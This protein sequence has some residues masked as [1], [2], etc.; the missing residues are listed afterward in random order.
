MGK[1]K[2]VTGAFRTCVRCKKE[3]PK[4]YFKISEWLKGDG[5]SVCFL[6]GDSD[7]KRSV[8]LVKCLGY[9]GGEFLS[10]HGERVCPL[11]KIKQAKFGEFRNG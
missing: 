7:K 5:L 8:K 9:C 6:C 2:V 10:Y 1:T 4:R 3:R 11:C